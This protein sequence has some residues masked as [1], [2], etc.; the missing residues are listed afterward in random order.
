MAQPKPDDRTALDRGAETVRSRYPFPFA[1]AALLGLGN[2]GGFSGARLWR[3]ESPAGRFCLRAWPAHETMARLQYRHRLMALAR[4]KGL[5]FVPAVFATVEGAT[6]VAEA[7]RL[8]ELTEWLDG[9]ADF[10]EFATPSR[11]EA[12]CEALAALHRA[13][14]CLAGPPIPCPA[15]Q[16]RL[17]FLRDWQALVTTGW[18]P[19]PQAADPLGDLARRAA[20]LLPRWLAGVPQ[21]LAPWAARALPVQPCLCDLWHDHLLFV[22]DRLTGLVDYGAVKLD[23]VAVDLARLLGSLVGDDAAGWEC[24]L[25]VYR[26]GRPLSPA[27]EELARVLDHTGAIL[28]LANWLR[29]LYHDGRAFEDLP[30]ARSHVEGL[31][32]RIEAWNPGTAVSVCPF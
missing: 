29:W 6:A 8:W 26:R 24:G 20:G 22:G 18:R 7:G 12:A 17:D 14:E 5:S 16:R 2:R 13:W 19:L 3:G 32:W 25:K 21:R 28:G 31:V 1:S 30:A 10:A 11:L 4:D 27:E 9:R 23:H 15:V